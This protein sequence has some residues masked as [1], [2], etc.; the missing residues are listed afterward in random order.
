MNSNTTLIV[1]VS[2]LSVII[3]LAVGL[4]VIKRRWKKTRQDSRD[5]PAG[6]DFKTYR[7]HDCIA[8]TNIN[9]FHHFMSLTK[10][11]RSR[12]SSRLRCCTRIA[13]M[14]T[15]NPKR[16]F[17]WRERLWSEVKM[18]LL[19]ITWAL[20]V[21]R[22]IRHLRSQSVFLG[23]AWQAIARWVHRMRMLTS[24]SQPFL[25]WASQEFHSSEWKLEWR[26]YPYF[27]RRVITDVET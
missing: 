20:S 12:C 10:R 27:S 18:N 11:K 16:T 1:I 19:H 21:S 14:C 24:Y 26:T 13:V 15:R 6:N 25:L 23:I 22:P 2:V 17:Q 7:R 3:V 9:Y 8:N 5:I 4:Y